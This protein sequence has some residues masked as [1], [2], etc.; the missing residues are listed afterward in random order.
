MLKRIILSS[1]IMKFG[2]S[3]Q[4]CTVQSFKRVIFVTNVPF[5]FAAI[6]NTVNPLVSPPY[7]F[8][9]QLTW[10][11]NRDRRFLRGVEGTYLISQRQWYQ[12]SIKN[13][14]YTE[15]KSSSTRSWMKS[16]IKNKSE[17]PDGE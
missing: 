9:T 2:R 3:L 14:K 5:H 11:L 8:Q 17:L 4:N 13:Y 7:L 1:G 16:R 6:A 15:S 10:G 12:F